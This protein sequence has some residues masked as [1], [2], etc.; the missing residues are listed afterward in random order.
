MFPKIRGVSPQIIHLFIGCSI[1]FTIHFGGKHPP[2]FGNIHIR[3]LSFFDD[4]EIVFDSKMEFLSISHRLGRHELPGNRGRR[5][6]FQLGWVTWYSPY[7][8]QCPIVIRETFNS[9]FH[10]FLKRMVFNMDIHTLQGTNRSDIGKREN[11]LQIYL[12]L[13]IC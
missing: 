10:V 1:I 2:I 7:F 12:G 9:T 6:K 5:F 3:S 4:S 8:P 11:H 13:G